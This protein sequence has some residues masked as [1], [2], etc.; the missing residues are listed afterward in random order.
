MS[1]LEK[2]K[3]KITHVPLVG[4]NNVLHKPTQAIDK[5]G[6]INYLNSLQ[7]DEL[8]QKEDR[9]KF[10]L[11]QLDKKQQQILPKISKN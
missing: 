1:F 4:Q 8:Q 11:K 10:E 5:K 6:W 3:G 2:F 9:L 7:G